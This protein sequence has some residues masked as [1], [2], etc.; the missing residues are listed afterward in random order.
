LYANGI[1]GTGQKLA[2]I[3][4]TDI[5]PADISD[6]RT[7][8]GLSGISGCTTKSGLITSCNTANFKYVLYLPPGGTDPLQPIGDIVEADLDI[9]WSGATAPGAQIIYV[10]APDFN[11]NGVLDSM[12]YAITQ[13]IAPVVSMSYGLCEVYSAENAAFGFPVFTEAQMQQANLQG[14]TIINSSGDWGAASCDPGN[15][16]QQ[17]YQV[18]S[19]ASLPEV[20]AVGGT[21]VP[22][23]NPDEYTPT[24]WNGTGTTGG[25]ALQ[26]MPEQVWNDDQE[27]GAICAASLEPYAT[28]LCNPLGI[29]DWSSAQ[30]LFGLSAGG[31]GVSNCATVDA[32][33][34]CDTAFPQPAYQANLNTS[35]VNPG[36]AG[37]L[38]AGVPTRYVPDVSLLSSPNFPGYI[39]CT[40]IEALSNTPPYN[41]ETTS[42]CAKGIASS[43]AGVISGGQYVVYPSIAGGTSF[44][45]PVFAGMVTLLNQYLNGPAS[46]GLGN[47]NPTLYTLAA[48]QS[49]LAFHQVTTGSVGAYCSAGSPS[50][51]PSGLQCPQVGFLGFDASNFDTTTCYNLAVGLGSVDL[52]NLALAWGTLAGNFTFTPDTPNQSQ[53][54]SAGQTSGAYSFTATPGGGAT[55]F[56]AP[57]YFSCS[58]SPSDPTLSNSSCIFSPAYVPAG[59]GASSVTMTLTTAGPNTPPGAPAKRS[60]RADKRSPWL[61]LTLP[62][63]GILFA[64]IAGRRVSKYSLLAGL[65]L[66][67]VL[68]GL[69]VAC[70]GGSSSNGGNT[71]PPPISVSVGPG[72]PSS[73]YPNNTADSWPSQTAQFTATVHNSSNQNITWSVSGGDANGTIDANG[74]YTAPQVAPGL[75]AKVTIVATSAADTSKSGSAQETLTP[76]TIPGTYTVNVTA[77]SGGTS[78]PSVPVTLVVQ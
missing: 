12:A 39:F 61:P 52:T 64:G 57:V 1:N 72:T 35:A 25:S 68:L 56:S 36:G 58:F 70:G 23:I 9:E 41:T 37:E 21:L 14:M 60:R 76:A 53:T 69:L 27:L 74:L 38:L 75:P 55:T 62:I 46:P 20:T 59:Q 77:T 18:S 42:S 26:Y 32:N 30:S 5:F 65:S 31:G 48:D 50:N 49:N 71:G 8:F 4:Q 13:A 3:G 34:V 47:I 54:V 73:V 17:G 28:D 11:G 16:V 33:L 15:P 78:L 29:T 45:A 24:Y 67:L 40:P 22:Q 51:Q 2:I 19:P 10:N 66:S 6:F 43:V 63:A 7:G 44:A